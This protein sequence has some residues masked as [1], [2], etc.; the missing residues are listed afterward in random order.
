MSAQKGQR[1]VVKG[2]Q[3]VRIIGGKWGSRRLQFPAALGLRPTIDRVRETL[4]NWLAFEL[5]GKSVLDAFSGSG[6]L[7]FEAASRGAKKV[8]MLEKQASVVSTLVGHAHTL[9]ADEQ[10]EI[11]AADTLK[12]FA[13]PPETAFDIIL[14]D[15]PFRQNMLQQSIDLI[16]ENGWLSSN[17]WVY[18]EYESDLTGLNIPSHWQC[19][20]EKQ[21]GQSVYALYRIEP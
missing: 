6:A 20:R 8:V 15:P 16:E 7:G 19:H 12:Y 10:L 14:L 17:A 21:A 2:S 18:M 3:Q 13:Q 11:Y 1:N 4:F 5:A 9:E